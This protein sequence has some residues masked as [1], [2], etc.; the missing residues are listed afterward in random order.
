MIAVDL[1]K[2]QLTLIPRADVQDFGLR[3]LRAKGAADMFRAGVP[4]R[5]CGW[6]SD[7]GSNQGRAD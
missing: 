1:G 2:L 4:I 6:L 7:L 3:D 5:Q